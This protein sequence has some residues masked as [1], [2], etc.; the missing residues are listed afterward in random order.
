MRGE[1]YVLHS[2]I[3]TEDEQSGLACVDL[4]RDDPKMVIELL[5]EN[6]I[7]LLAKQ[8]SIK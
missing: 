4:H 5:N 6:E 7:S 3:P 1:E 2:P 8:P